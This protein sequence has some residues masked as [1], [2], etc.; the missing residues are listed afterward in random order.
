MMD[1]AVFYNKVRNSDLLGPVLSAE[2][3][4]GLEAIVKAATCRDDIGAARLAYMLATA[5]HETAGTMQPIREIGSNAYLTNAYDIRGRNPARARQY[6]NITPG[7]GIKYCGRGFVQLT[8]RS[9]Y[10]KAGE[11]LKIELVEHPELAMQVGIAAQ[12]MVEGMCEGWFTGATVL[13]KLPFGRQAT[14]EEFIKAR[15][16]I[17]STDRAER[18]ANYA[19]KFQ[20]YLTEAGMK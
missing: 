14:L 4:E 10:I 6:G 18:I 9:N 19:L 2:E 15:A 8:W 17:N 12:V 1:W 16:I 11:Q 7:D 13:K 5:Y 20:K 3:F